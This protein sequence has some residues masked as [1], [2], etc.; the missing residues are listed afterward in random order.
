MSHTVAFGQVSAAVYEL[1]GTAITHESSPSVLLHQSRWSTC[2]SVSVQQGGDMRP[3]LSS[4]A[5]LIDTDID[6]SL[7]RQEAK[8]S[9]LTNLQASVATF[10]LGPGSH[11][12]AQWLLA[13]PPPGSVV[14]VLPFS[15]SHQ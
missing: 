3:P 2:N 14:V 8:S 11:V 5:V 1:D 12:T 15:I 7:R 9:C 4:R 6:Q 10:R 13:D